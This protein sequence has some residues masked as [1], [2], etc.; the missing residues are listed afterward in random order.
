VIVI[1][2]NT[3]RADAGIVIDLDAALNVKFHTAPDKNAIAN[4]NAGPG[5]PV[6]VEFEIDIWFEYTS[7]SDFKLVR[8]GDYAFRDRGPD[9]NSCAKQL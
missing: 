2:Q 4:A 5:L 6:P 8:P 1:R 3:S 9:T 7:A